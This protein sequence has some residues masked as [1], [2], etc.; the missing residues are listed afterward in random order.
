MKTLKILV[1]TLMIFIFY[2]YFVISDL[3][4]ESSKKDTALKLYI[5]ELLQDRNNECLLKEKQEEIDYLKIK[6]SEC[7]TLK[8]EYNNWLK[9]R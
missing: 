9:N 4:I 8:K 5:S 1:I 3:I 7:V 2:L 6:I